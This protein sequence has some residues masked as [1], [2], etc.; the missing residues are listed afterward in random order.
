MDFKAINNNT[1]VIADDVLIVGD[2]SKAR[3]G[4][5]DHR[6]IQVLKTAVD[7]FEAQC[8]QMYLQVHTSLIFWTSRHQQ[9]T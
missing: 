9:R 4:N 3:T 2:S 7:R 6:L 1:H 5:Y 8:R